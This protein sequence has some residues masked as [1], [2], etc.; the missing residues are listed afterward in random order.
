MSLR[1]DGTTGT[2]SSI[3]ISRSS[4]PS[5][6][7]EQ[8]P[9]TA[10]AASSGG[11]VGPTSSQHGSPRGVRSRRSAN[12]TP[13][14]PSTPAF[15]SAQTVA[16]VVD[17]DVTRPSLKRITD[18]TTS[19]LVEAASLHSQRHGSNSHTPAKTSFDELQRPTPSSV[20]REK[21]VIV[22]QISKSD[23]IASIALQY[24]I[25]PQA[26]RSSNRL[27]HS[28]SIHLRKTL[29]IPLDLCHLPSASAGIERIEREEDGNIVVWQRDRVPSSSTTILPSSASQNLSAAPAPSSSSRPGVISPR[30]RR[31]HSGSTIGLDDWQRTHSTADL[32]G[33]DATTP[34]E[35]PDDPRLG[36]SSGVFDAI[37][38][39]TSPASTAD[40]KGKGRAVD[41]VAAY[42]PSTNNPYSATSSPVPP[43]PASDLAGLSGSSDAYPSPTQ[44]PFGGGGSGGHAGGSSTASLS[45]PP[46]SRRVLTITRVP[47][48]SL[49]F[50]P[51]SSNGS[52][53]SARSSLSE[54][55]Y[56]N[57]SLKGS[58]FGPLANSLA[59]LNISSTAP[60]LTNGK[61]GS[62]WS[63]GGATS[64]TNSKSRQ[65]AS[66]YA[67]LNPASHHRMTSTLSSSDRRKPSE[68]AKRSK[69]DL[70]YFGGEE[71]AESAVVSMTTT[72]TSKGSRSKDRSRDRNRT[73][74]QAS[75]DKANGDSNGNSL[76]SSMWAG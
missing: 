73:P 11:T 21:E 14:P 44:S 45:P 74:T 42:L 9:L 1:A 6:W 59:K 41:A 2:S 43:S 13:N 64:T 62:A 23:T 57:A 66:D 24:G 20:A 65:A 36:G 75:V 63:T 56:H 17:N 7:S 50:F 55:E 68:T 3:V 28:D 32:L 19:T 22:H 61:L 40:L 46:I 34:T 25:T 15:P 16:A 71:E 18:S 26:L 52:S 30:A 10:A 67:N 33:L 12:S 27:W 37:W 49:A 8:H 48:S 31:L 51:P 29:N 76:W 53:S 70:A 5:A 54:E 58:F 39:T 60:G 69:W 38:R 47:E 72:S 4:S 35:L